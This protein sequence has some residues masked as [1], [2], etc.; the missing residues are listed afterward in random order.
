MSTLI[1]RKNS[2]PNNK[3]ILNKDRPETLKLTAINQEN[4]GLF[5]H[6]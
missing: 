3:Q 1:E 4:N 5:I 2:N 6:T